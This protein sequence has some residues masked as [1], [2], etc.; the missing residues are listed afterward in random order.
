MHTRL[1]SPWGNVHVRL[2]DDQMLHVRAETDLAAIW[3]QGYA[4]GR[5]RLWQLDLTRRA[6]RGEL[7]QILGSRARR[8]DIFQRKL[9]LSGLAERE[10]ARVADLSALS[11][12]D[13]RQVNQVR[14]YVD[15]INT[16]LARVRLLPPEC[17]LLRYRPAPFAETD[18]YAAA[19][20]KYFINSA[21]QFE[22]FHTRLSGRLTT[23]QAGQLFATFSHE[24]GVLPPLPRTGGTLTASAARALEDGLAGLR[25]LGMSSPDSGSNVFAVSGAR[26]ATGFPLL[27]SDPHMGQV[28]PGYNLLCTLHSDD[29]LWVSGSH[30]PGIPGVIVGRNRVAAWGMVGIMADNQDLFWGETDLKN[31]RVHT[32]EGSLPLERREETIAVR[33]SKKGLTLFTFGFAGGRLIQAHDGRALFLRWPALDSPLGDITLAGL[34]RCDNW[35]SFRNGVRRL[36]N[37]P[38]MVGY[39]D[40]GGNIGL[41]TTGLFPRRSSPLGSLL[42]SLDDPSATWRGYLDFD[43]LPSTYNPPEGYVIHANQYSEAM[44]AHGPHLTNRWHA[45]SRALRIEERL[46][47]IKAHTPET[48]AEIQDD[49]LDIFARRTLPRLRPLLPEQSPLRQWNGDTRDVAASRLFDAVIE[50][51]AALLTQDRLGPKTLALY[52]DFWP[53]FR[54][55]V[56]HILEHGLTDWPCGHDSVTADDLLRQAYTRAVLRPPLIAESAFRHTLQKPAWLGRLL[57]GAQPHIGGN[58]ETV[59]AARQNMDFL[60]SQLGTGPSQCRPYSFGPAFKLVMDLSPDGGLRYLSSMPAKGAPFR[61][62]LRATLNRWRK[63]ERRQL[64]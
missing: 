43:E 30:F 3:G 6:A 23:A 32:A 61:W 51:L 8:G 64:R 60:T 33:G 50:E 4:V 45:P 9:G 56:W 16:A 48:L 35:Q 5:L 53:S 1:H 7:A 17:L 19:L 54:W 38:M 29:G 46:M 41:Q 52:M 10:A 55:S 37:S 31:D 58:R 15:G 24:G 49:L 14:A 21:W 20:L 36:H 26:S 25:L 44:F 59:H 28:N 40:A 13:L 42:R 11:G 27:A 18:V 22:I 12:D 39:A 62:N 2:L 47:E 63:R 34:A 57:T